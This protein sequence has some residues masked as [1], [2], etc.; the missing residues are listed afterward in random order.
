[1]KNLHIFLYLT[2]FYNFFYNTILVNSTFGNKINL[3]VSWISREENTLAE[4][5]SKRTDYDDRYIAQKSF[6]ILTQR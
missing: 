5:L 6:S 1:M 3:E 4:K 2:P